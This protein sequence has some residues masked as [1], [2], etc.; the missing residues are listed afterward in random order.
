VL[1]VAGWSWL[2]VGMLACI[3][4]FLPLNFPRAR[5]FLGDVGSGA[6]GLA[7]AIFAIAAL[8]PD[9]RPARLTLFLLPAAAFLVDASLTLLRRVARRERWWTPHTQHLYQG[10]ARRFGHPRVTAA[11]AAWSCFG[12]LLIVVLKDRPEAVTWPCV[13]VWYTAS[14][15]AWAWAQHSIAG[16]T[17]A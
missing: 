7:V 14:A 6:L 8:G 16:K 3:A 10:L 4:G 13:V 17:T 1:G 11:Y 5:I 9:A 2:A 15:A 12:L